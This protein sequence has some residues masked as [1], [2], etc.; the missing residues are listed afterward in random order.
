[1]GQYRPNFD[2]GDLVPLFSKAELLN[3]RLR[4]HCQ[5]LTFQYAPIVSGPP[6]LQIAKQQDIAV[7]QLPHT[8]AAALLSDRGS[9]SAVAAPKMATTVVSPGDSLWRISRVTYGAGMRY[10][11]VYKANWDHIRNPIVSIPARSLFF[12]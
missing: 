6:P 12:L 11:V 8:T 10:A 1:M 9:P 7:S 5:K 4:A 2:S 3:S